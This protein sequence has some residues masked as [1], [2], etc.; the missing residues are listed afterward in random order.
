M[1]VTIRKSKASGT[2]A[3]P[4]SKSVAHRALICGAFSQKSIIKNIEY[5]ADI[6]ATLSC[7]ESL[8]AKVKRDKDFV[9]IGGLSKD[10]IKEG[11]ELFCDESGS[12]LRFMIPICLLSG[13]KVTL[14]GS[15]RLF[16]RPLSVYEK[17]FVENK[18]E[19]EKGENF[20][21]LCGNIKSGNYEIEGNIS[22]QF[23]TGLMFT[24]VNLNEPS[25]I[26]VT[27]GFE[28]E[29]YVNLTVKVLRDFGIDIKRKENTYII[30]A[31]QTFNCP[32]YTVEGDYSNAAFL[33]AFNL[34][35]SDVRV[36]GLDEDSVQGD[37]VYKKM[38]EQL[39]GGVRDFDLSD[40]PDLAPVLFALSAALGGAHFKGTARLKIKES[41]RAEAMK[42]ELEK[43]GIAVKVEQNDVYVENGTLK[44]PKTI[45]FGH[46]DHRI[47]MALSVICSIVGGTISGAQAINKSF[48][49]FFNKI[50]SLKVGV[51]TDED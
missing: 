37:K 19:Y 27:G 38:Y 42:Q 1:T 7:L 10:G 31:G 21:T 11:T 12:T 46:N 51:M 6:I 43:F 17:I 32:E 33:D 48:P 23:I 22:S 35:G 36:S 25:S 50:S 14:K 24:L 8:G 40:C 5:S 13:K 3:A 47:V 9:E 44:P 15:G 49:D 41:D 18:I 34:L 39:K 45:L 30:G 26:T 4:P 2:V 28:S 20:I 16:A 29:S